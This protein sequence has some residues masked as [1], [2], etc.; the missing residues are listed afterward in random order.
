MVRTMHAEAPNDSVAAAP[1]WLVL[2]AMLN[3]QPEPCSDGLSGRASM[4]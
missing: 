2:A 4:G 1:Y 3:P